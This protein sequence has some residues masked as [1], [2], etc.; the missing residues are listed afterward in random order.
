MQGSDRIRLS[1]GDAMEHG[2]QCPNCG[3]YTSFV[4][5]LATGQCRGGWPGGCETRLS[6]DLV[7]DDGL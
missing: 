6:L 3:I 4:D 2:V 5:I 1:E 7:V